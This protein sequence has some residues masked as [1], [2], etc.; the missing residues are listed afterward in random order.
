MGFTAAASACADVMPLF[1]FP[2]GVVRGASLDMIS[3]Q[4]SR[5]CARADRAN[6]RL[7]KVLNEG[8]FAVTDCPSE[9]DVGRPDP[10]PPPLAQRSQAFSDCDRRL[11]LTQKFIKLHSC[12]S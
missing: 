5:L 8:W 6:L 7:A 4:L 11:L 2:R 10:S 3:L 1:G 9:Q 12:I